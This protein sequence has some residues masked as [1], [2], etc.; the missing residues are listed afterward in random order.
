MDLGSKGASQRLESLGMRRAALLLLL[1]VLGGILAALTE[2]ATVD[3]ELW[4]RMLWQPAVV[5]LAL[6]G[7]TL[8]GIVMA[9][10]MLWA[11]RRRSLAISVPAT[12]G[13]AIVAVALVNILHVPH[14]LFVGFALVASFIFIY[15]L[16]TTR[17]E[18]SD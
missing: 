4:L 13:F 8:G 11:F 7:G 9:P 6:I 1:S 10:L 17:A 16:L 3:Q 2:A 15:G 12:Y 14:S 5:P 18:R